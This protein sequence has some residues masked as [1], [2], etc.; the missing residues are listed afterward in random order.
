[1]AQVADPEAQYRAA[2]SNLEETLTDLCLRVNHG[3]SLKATQ[4]SR[5]DAK[6][7]CHWIEEAVEY[8]VAALRLD[9]LREIHRIAEA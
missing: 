6:L 8:K 4:T 7:I 9:I 1:V 2:L 3:H 5:G